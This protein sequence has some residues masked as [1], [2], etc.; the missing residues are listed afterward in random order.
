MDPAPLSK[1][2]SC[3]I[4]PSPS[5]RTV[6]VANGRLARMRIRSLDGLRGLASLVVA[7][8]HALLCLAPLSLVY[9]DPLKVEKGT[10]AWWL[11][12]TPLH[13][14][15]AGGEAVYLFFVLSGFVLARPF[16]GGRSSTWR[17]YFVK[18][19]PRLYLPVWVAVG[20]ALVSAALT[21]TMVPSSERV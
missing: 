1:L 16:L 19:I 13:A 18:R 5:D 3:Q 15:W 9:F 10:K 21:W 17:T 7:V 11:G 14:A 20:F 12:F 4:L 2:G 6:S 8:H